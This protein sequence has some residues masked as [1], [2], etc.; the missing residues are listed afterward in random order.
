MKFIIFQNE[1]HIK[2]SKMKTLSEPNYYIISLLLLV[3]HFLTQLFL[4]KRINKNHALF[5]IFLVENAISLSLTLAINLKEIIKH[6]KY[7]IIYIISVM[8]L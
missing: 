6:V 8:I 4:S 2:Y 7:F 3:H 5:F 1:I